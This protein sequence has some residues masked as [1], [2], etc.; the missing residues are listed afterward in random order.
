MSLYSK[1]LT[2]NTDKGE[3]IPSNGIYILRNNSKY[4]K[5]E[6]W[7]KSWNSTAI[8]V[9]IIDYSLPNKGFIIDKYNRGDENTD[10][11]G[12]PQTDLAGYGTS[13]LPEYSNASSA[14]ADKNGIHNTKVFLEETSGDSSDAVNFCSTRYIYVGGKVYYGYV[15]AVGEWEL[16]RLNFDI[17]EEMML[18]IGGT[19]LYGGLFGNKYNSLSYWT[20][21]QQ[22]Y[23][24]SRAFKITDAWGNLEITIA[25]I[26]GGNNMARGLSFFPLVNFE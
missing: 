12:Y 8:G 17:I 14:K 24:D 20:S 10:Y 22:D 16:V 3:A 13:L 26:G 2:L 23:S 15:G 6:D 9:A 1:L 18:Y 7:D 19:T 25:P 21:T 11:L 4:Y 5:Y